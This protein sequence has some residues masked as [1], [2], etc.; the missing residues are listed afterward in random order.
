MQPPLL[1]P[2]CHAFQAAAADLDRDGRVEFAIACTGEPNLV[3]HLTEAGV[4]ETVWSSPEVENTQC[5]S[6][7]DIDDDGDAD[8]ATAGYGDLARIYRNDRGTLVLGWSAPKPTQSKDCE[9]ADIDGDSDL[10]LVVAGSGTDQIYINE[11]GAFRDARSVFLGD[12]TDDVALFDFDKDG[13]LD[14]L[15][16]ISGKNSPDLLFRNE[17]G[18]FLRH[19]ETPAALQGSSVSWTDYDRDGRADFAIGRPNDPDE[20]WR[21]TSAGEFECV[22]WNNPPSHT[23]EVLWA[24]FDRDQWPDLLVGREAPLE[25]WRNVSTVMTPTALAG[26]EALVEAVAVGDADGD[27]NPDLLVAARDGDRKAQPLIRI[28]LGG[29]PPAAPRVDEP[30]P[31]LMAPELPDRPPEAKPSLLS[32]LLKFLFKT[33]L[34]VAMLFGGWRASQFIKTLD[35]R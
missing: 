14:L 7:G 34:L 5:V 23:R 32:R 11:G 29:P 12:E 3:V 13:D 8:L 2:A 15:A 6:W 35:K 26:E 22:L 18:S 28:Y 31:D 17:S 1:G 30:E 20:I 4:I 33:L 27:G 21:Q 16:A 9:L 19:W 10:D 24:D 25:I